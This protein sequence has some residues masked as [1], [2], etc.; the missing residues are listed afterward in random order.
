VPIS[1][2]VRVWIAATYFAGAIDTG[3]ALFQVA[4][5]AVTAG[6]IRVAAADRAATIAIAGLAFIWVATGLASA[7]TIADTTLTVIPVA[8]TPAIAARRLGSGI[9]FFLARGIVRVR[10][11]TAIASAAIGNAAHTSPSPC[12]PVKIVAVARRTPRSGAEGIVRNNT[13]K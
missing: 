13:Q 6:L 2:A 5:G 4:A 3:L 7:G 11:V 12:V 9:E 10:C 8:N 1:A